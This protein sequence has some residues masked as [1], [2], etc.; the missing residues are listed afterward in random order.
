M[1]VILSMNSN[2]YLLIQYPYVH[3]W[4]KKGNLDNRVHEWKKPFYKKPRFSIFREQTNGKT[5]P[6][7]FKTVG[8]IKKDG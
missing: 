5:I 3:I 8:Y 1:S 7:C 2:V 6:Y 4:T